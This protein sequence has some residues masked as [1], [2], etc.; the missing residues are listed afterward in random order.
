[1]IGW[2]GVFARLDL[3]DLAAG[4]CFL[5]VVAHGFAHWPASAI[6]RRHGRDAVPT[7]VAVRALENL[8]GELHLA[9][10][11][12]IDVDLRGQSDPFF[13]PSRLSADFGGGL[14]HLVRRATRLVRAEDLDLPDDRR[15]D[16]VDLCAEADAERTAA[17][18]QS[19]DEKVTRLHAA[20]T[21][22]NDRWLSGGEP[23]RLADMARVV[24]EAM[25]CAV[26]EGADA[27]TRWLDP[28]R[29]EIRT[30][31]YLLRHVGRLSGRQAQEQLMATGYRSREGR[32][33]PYNSIP[34]YASQARKAVN[35]V[36]G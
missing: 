33:Y 34:S 10:D 2:S 36:L 6:A 5:H 26:G 17:A 1:V 11:R 23:Y 24:T 15:S 22:L 4:R 30:A 12:S 27:L 29:L 20:L 3:G 25:R 31:C 16:T 7:E 21:A 9:P 8:I 13:E 32:P 19:V 14:L 35:E 28:R 18:R